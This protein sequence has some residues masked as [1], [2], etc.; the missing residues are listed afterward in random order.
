MTMNPDSRLHCIGFDGCCVSPVPSSQRGEYVIPGTTTNVP[1]LDNIGAAGY[2]RNR[3]NDRI[4]LNRRGGTTQGIFQCQIRTEPTQTML[5][6]FYIGV[7]DAGSGENDYTQCSIV[8]IITYNLCRNT[9]YH[10]HNI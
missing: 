2:Y 5:Q 4:F 1:T 6:T 7:Y 3:R 8:Y 9:Q 10:Q